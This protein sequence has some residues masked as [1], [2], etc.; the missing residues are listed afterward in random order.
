MEICDPLPD[1]FEHK[2][3]NRIAISS[4]K[5]ERRPGALCNAQIIR[6]KLADI[7]CRTKM[8]QHNIQKHSQAHVMGC[9]EPGVAVPVARRSCSVRR[10]ISTI[11]TPVPRARR[12]VIGINFQGRNAQLLE[13]LQSRNDRFQSSL[14]GKRADV[15]LVED[16]IFAAQTSPILIRPGERLGRVDHQW[17]M[18]YP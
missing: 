5:I 1:I 15:Q 13:R 2:I 8:V 16:E 7:V 17:Q 9:V 11:V 12:L 4:V 18:K 14:V 10:Q 3:A 6:R